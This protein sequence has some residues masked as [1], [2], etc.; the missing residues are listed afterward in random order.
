MARLKIELLFQKM[1]ICWELF[2]LYFKLEC[3]FMQTVPF[4]QI[5]ISGDSPDIHHTRL[6]LRPEEG[7][8]KCRKCWKNLVIL[9]R[10]WG[11]ERNDGGHFESFNTSRKEKED[12]RLRNINIQPSRE[13]EVKINVERVSLKCCGG[14]RCGERRAINLSSWSSLTGLHTGASFPSTHP[15]KWSPVMDHGNKFVPI[16]REEYTQSIITVSGSCPVF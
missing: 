2:L 3:H 7:N 16:F 12:Q 14:E 6:Y 4:S 5:N 15:G 8:M 9:S 10:K 13:G 1:K 11:H